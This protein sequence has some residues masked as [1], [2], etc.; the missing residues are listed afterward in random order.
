M[1]NYQL[2]LTKVEQAWWVHLGAFP[3]PGKLSYPV[4]DL[5]DMVASESPKPYDNMTN[6]D[7]VGFL[8]N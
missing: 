2:A 6:F 5:T 3:K 4:L 8:L 7:E 1:A